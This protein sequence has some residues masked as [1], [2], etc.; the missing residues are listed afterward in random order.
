MKLAACGSALASPGP[1]D[2]SRYFDA[3]AGISSVCVV[4]DLGFMIGIHTWGVAAR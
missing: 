2:S 3:F 4:N 1:I